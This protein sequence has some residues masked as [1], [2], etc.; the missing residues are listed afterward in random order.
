MKHQPSGKSL[1]WMIGLLAFSVASTSYAI[2]SSVIGPDSVTVAPGAE[3]TFELAIDNASLTSTVGIQVVLSGMSAGGAVLTSGRSAFEHFTP[4]CSPST[5]FGGINTLSSFFN[6]NDLGASGAYIPGDDSALVVNAISSSGATT[7]SGA[8]D[9]GLIGAPNEPS[10]LDVVM[11]LTAQT[12]GLL[13][14]FVNGSYSD[15]ASVFPLG[16]PTLTVNVVP[17]PGSALLIAV[18]L[19]GL[20][21]SHTRGDRIQSVMNRNS[22]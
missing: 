16:G 1:G 10:A 11:N 13:Q 5:C 3:F 19:A 2:E 17:E 9:P 12:P 20:S 22:A 4:F 21:A 6:P 18:G 8:G 14:L 15:G 7:A